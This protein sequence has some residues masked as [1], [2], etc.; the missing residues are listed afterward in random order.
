MNTLKP[1]AGGI[2]FEDG[3]APYFFNFLL[4]SLAVYSSRVCPLLVRYLEHFCILKIFRKSFKPTQFCNVKSET[5]PT[6]SQQSLVI[7]Q[8]TG[9][10]F[11][12]LV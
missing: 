5:V 6:N 1:D 3:S 11:I 4:I 7:Y 10:I 2:T 12:C 8:L 9:P